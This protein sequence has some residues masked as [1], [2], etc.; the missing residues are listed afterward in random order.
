MLVEGITA[1]TG[2]PNTT[3]V[4]PESYFFDLYFM[5]EPHIYDASFVKLREVKVGFDLPQMLLRYL[6]ITGARLTLVGRNL[7]LSTD[8]PNID[9]ETAFDTSNRQGFEFGQL[10]TPKS[11]GF[12]LSIQP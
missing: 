5:D 11:F 2:Q 9:P 3:P 7:W 4:C 1:S 6:P 10:P 12:N 8:A